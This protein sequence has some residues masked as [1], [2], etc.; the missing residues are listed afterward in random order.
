MVEAVSMEHEIDFQ[1]RL[2]HMPS[3]LFF[4]FPPFLFYW[5]LE[6]TSITRRVHFS[7]NTEY[8]PSR[9]LLHLSH[10]RPRYNAYAGFVGFTPLPTTAYPGT[11]NPI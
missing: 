8:V 2:L 5:N 11:R 6:T 10:P 1:L 3:A 9:V 4:F 7:H